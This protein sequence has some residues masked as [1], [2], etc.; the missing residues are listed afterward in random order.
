M[1]SWKTKLRANDLPEN[2]K[3]EASCRKCG[4]VRYLS[5]SYLVAERGAGHLY[6]DQIENRSRCQ[7]LGCGGG[8]RLAMMH[9]GQT[10]GFVGGM[11]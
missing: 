10:S 9:G 6:I 1:G 2:C 5:Q 11:A 4:H 7:V 8:M 3:L